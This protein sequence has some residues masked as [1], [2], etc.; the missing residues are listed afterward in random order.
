MQ[1]NKVSHESLIKQYVTC[2]IISR[3]W[4]NHTM[5]IITS[6]S[7]KAETADIR[8]EWTFM[9][10]HASTANS[11]FLRTGSARYF[12]YS[13]PTAY[14]E[15][16]RPTVYFDFEEGQKCLFILSWCPYPDKILQYT[17]YASPSPTPPQ[18]I[19]TVF[20]LLLHEKG[21]FT[22]SMAETKSLLSSKWPCSIEL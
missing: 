10:C 12:S 8:Q 18:K 5:F 11:Y 7:W 3:W 9:S 4:V 20:I 2:C 21:I 13:L 14:R 1:R 15:R 17:V 19:V 22:S 16:R 6:D